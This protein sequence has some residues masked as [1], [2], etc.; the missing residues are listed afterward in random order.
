MSSP[1]SSGFIRQELGTTKADIELAIVGNF[2]DFWEA[3]AGIRPV[4]MPNE[5]NDFDFRMVLPGGEVDLELT[6]LLF[7]SATSGSPYVQPNRMRT[8]GEA[9]DTV[10]ARIADKA[11]H[12]QRVT[13][14]LHLLIYVTHDPF[15]LVDDGITLVQW[16]L[17]NRPPPVFENIFFL[18]LLSVAPVVRCLYPVPLSLLEGFDEKAAR[19]REYVVY[20]LSQATIARGNS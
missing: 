20:D 4:I 1:G 13:R 12:Y 9:A 19:D 2:A 5:E 11:T 18:T 15:E 17:A 3:T 14:P 10:I 6:E 7:P 16:E 8:H